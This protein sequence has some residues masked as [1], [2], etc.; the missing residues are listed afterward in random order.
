MSLKPYTDRGPLLVGVSSVL[1]LLVVLGVLEYRDYHRRSH[2]DFA[3]HRRSEGLVIMLQYAIMTYWQDHSDFQPEPNREMLR[4][5]S[6]EEY[7]LRS[8]L[9]EWDCIRDERLV[10]AWGTPYQYC[11]FKVGSRRGY[12]LYSLG[13]NMRDDGWRVDDVGRCNAVSA[14]MEHCEWFSVRPSW[15]T[16]SKKDTGVRT[17]RSRRTADS[18][19]AGRS[20]EL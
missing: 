6:A 20:R 4:V 14:A 16:L 10:D 19:P 13:G 7:V 11:H 2:G 5:L 17:N 9:Q 18:M 8:F 1:V 12:A 15:L 3:K